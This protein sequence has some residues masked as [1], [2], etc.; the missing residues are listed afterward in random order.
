M[1]ARIPSP[2]RLRRA[3]GAL[4]RRSLSEGGKSGHDEFAGGST[5]PSRDA[6]RPSFLKFMSL[7]KNGG[8]RECRARAAPAASY[9]NKESI[10][11]SHHRSAATIRHSL[12]DGFTGSFVLAP[13]TG[14]FCLRPRCDA[15]A[16]SPGW[17]QRRD[18]GPTRLLRPLQARSSAALK[19]PSRPA[20]NVRDDRDTPLIKGTGRG[21][22]C[23]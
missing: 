21:K 8:R 22:K 17:Y 13:E 6:P 19:R 7:P 4:G 20:P 16:S 14:L 11:V 9:A 23:P 15:K 12:H 18:T 10:R 3:T 5:G 2:P 1:D